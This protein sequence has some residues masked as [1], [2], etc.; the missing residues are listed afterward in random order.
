MASISGIAQRLRYWP[1][2]QND[3]S[4]HAEPRVGV[5]FITGDE[6]GEWRQ[7]PISLIPLALGASLGR[8][9]TVCYGIGRSV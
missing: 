3:G 6:P 2:A 9:Q 4:E 1:C 8:G 5:D 7:D